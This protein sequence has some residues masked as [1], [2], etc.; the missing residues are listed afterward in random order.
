MTVAQQTYHNVI[1]D[2]GTRLDLTETVLFRRAQCDL[3][4]NAGRHP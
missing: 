2:I 3:S 4:G 1:V